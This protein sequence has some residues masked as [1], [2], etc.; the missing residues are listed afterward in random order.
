MADR[1]SA[2]IA[3]G[4]TLPRSRLDELTTIITDQD[5]RLDW[6]GA[7][8]K[9]DDIPADAPIELVAHEV[10]WGC[11]STLEQF[12]KDHALAY[13]RWSGGCSGSFG[14]ERVIFTGSGL[15]QSHCVTEDDELVF[16]LDTIRAL[17]SIAAI[18]AQAAEADFT[19]GPLTI[20]DDGPAETAEVAH[21]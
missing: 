19:P 7:P 17:G 4:G 20:V 12:C 11:F 21:G 13:A 14:P 5:L 8:F 3:I 6:E 1:V 2:S 9:P 15:P 16:G 10:A 18:E